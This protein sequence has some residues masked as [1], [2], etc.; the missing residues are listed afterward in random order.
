MYCMVHT[1]VNCVAPWEEARRQHSIEHTTVS[2]LSC[3]SVWCCKVVVILR[4]RR[5]TR[6]LKFAMLSRQNLWK[7]EPADCAEAMH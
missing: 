4:E 6:G 5:L 3:M 7:I 2:V 1:H